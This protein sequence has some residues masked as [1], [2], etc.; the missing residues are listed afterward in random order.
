MTHDGT[1]SRL[2]RILAVTAGLVLTGAIVG[3][4]TSAVALLLVSLSDGVHGM[5]EATSG[6]GFAAIAGAAIGGVLA[7]V[8]AWVLLRRVPLWRAIA[9]TA[10]GTIIGALVLGFLVPGPIIGAV[11]GFTIAAIRLRIVT[12]VRNPKARGEPPALTP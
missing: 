3:A 4:I 2:R 12:R 8:E 5:A 10:A 9:E 6:L 1:P 7:P 11:A